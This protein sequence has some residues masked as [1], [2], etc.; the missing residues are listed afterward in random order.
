MARRAKRELPEKPWATTG[1]HGERKPNIINSLYI[2]P[3]VCA[4]HNVRLAE[5]YRAME[6]NETRWEETDTEDCEVLF[7]AYGT[8]S[9]IAKAAIRQLAK[10]GIRAGLFRPITLWPFPGKALK[11]AAHAAELQ[12][13]RGCGA[14]HGPDDRRC[15]DR[16]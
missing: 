2:D 14:E 7:V 11:Q 10:E 1:T 3:N 5:K 13:G 6:E 12:G 9:R 15:E 8:P 4:E 16:A